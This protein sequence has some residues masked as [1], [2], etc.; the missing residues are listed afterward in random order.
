MKQDTAQK[1]RG[2][3]TN[4]LIDENSVDGLS[5]STEARLCS[6][7]SREEEAPILSNRIQEKTMPSIL[8]N[9]T[10]VEIT[11]TTEHTIENSILKIDR[12]SDIRQN[13]RNN[14]NGNN[15]I[16]MTKT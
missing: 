2:L 3:I 10:V 8:E 16:P 4:A 9:V 6:V 15:K 5:P 7:S 13:N 12:G 14:Y 11:P 1:V